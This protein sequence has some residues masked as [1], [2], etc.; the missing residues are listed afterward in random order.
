MQIVYDRVVII[1]PVSRRGGTGFVGGDPN[2]FG[3]VPV[4]VPRIERTSFP[5]VM[6]S[7]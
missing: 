7:R 3:M 1:A 4:V 5:Q 2:Y 6:L